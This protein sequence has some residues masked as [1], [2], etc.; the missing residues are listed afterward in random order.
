MRKPTI[1]EYIFIYKNDSYG[2]PRY[3]TNKI[4]WNGIKS[5]IKKGLINLWKLT[6]YLLQYIIPIAIAY[7]MDKKK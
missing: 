7:F 6:K 4:N 1:L 5:L 2:W 3:R